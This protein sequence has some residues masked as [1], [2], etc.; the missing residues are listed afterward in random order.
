MLPIHVEVWMRGNRLKHR[1]EPFQRLVFCVY[2]TFSGQTGSKS[3]MERALHTFRHKYFNQ[4]LYE[5]KKL[6]QR[7]KAFVRRLKDFDDLKKASKKDYVALYKDL[8]AYKS[9]VWDGGHCDGVPVFAKWKPDLLECPD[10]Y[11]DW[12]KDEVACVLREFELEPHKCAVSNTKFVWK[13]SDVP[14][15]VRII[16]E[17]CEP[18]EK[19]QRVIETLRSYL[20]EVRPAISHVSNTFLTIYE[21][22][23]TRTDTPVEELLHD[24]YKKRMPGEYDNVVAKRALKERSMELVERLAEAE[25]RANKNNSLYKECALSLNN[26]SRRLAELE[27]TLSRYQRALKERDDIIRNW[28]RPNSGIY[29]RR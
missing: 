6:S 22:M 2:S 8:C 19:V 7:E 9:C 23:S 5:N 26:I 27:E 25:E 1:L 20:V 12:Y 10:I 14:A 28:S 21:E 16:S 3:E 24:L 13:T 15:S 11:K 4:Y 18:T 17:E 29:N